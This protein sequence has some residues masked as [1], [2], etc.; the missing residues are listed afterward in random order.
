MFNLEADTIKANSTLWRCLSYL[1]V[2][3][4]LN[5]SIATVHRTKVLG[6]LKTE[7]SSSLG[8]LDSKTT[9]SF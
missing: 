6:R 7:R 8:S 1:Q 9:Y 3:E 2:L 4:A 5:T